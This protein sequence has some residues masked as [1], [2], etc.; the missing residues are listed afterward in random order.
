MISFSI[1]ILTAV[2]PPANVGCTRW[3]MPATRYEAVLFLVSD[4]WLASKWCVDEYQ[5]ANRL[6][7]KLLAPLI[8]DIALD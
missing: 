6:N 3:K 4:D 1:S 7:K 8:D 5:L 2:L